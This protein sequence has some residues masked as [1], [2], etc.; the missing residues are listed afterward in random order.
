MDM[1]ESQLN[2][3]WP[4]TVR[5]ATVLRA[6]S[7]ISGSNSSENKAANPNGLADILHSRL[8]Q[9]DTIIDDISRT[10][11]LD[12]QSLQL[13]T[14][15]ASLYVLERV[16][17][18]LVEHEEQHSKDSAVS[19]P[20]GSKDMAQIRTHIS[21]VFN[22]GTELLTSRILPSLPD[23]PMR[24]PAIP[25]GAQIIDLTATHENYTLLFDIATRLLSIIFPEGP[26]G[27]SSTTFVAMTIWSRG[28]TDLLKTCI[29]LAWL[30]S[31][32]RGDVSPVLDVKPYIS[33][34]L[35]ASSPAQSI[36]ALGS[37][38]RK[39]QKPLY[40][41]KICRMLSTEQLLRP[42]GIA[43][44]LSSIFGEDLSS[45][46]APLEKLQSTSN[47]LNT[48]PAHMSP[49]EYYPIIIPRLLQLLS[50]STNKTIPPSHRR[51]ASFALSRMLTT[52]SDA[53][54]A[55][56]ADVRRD[57]VAWCLL[58]SFRPV[59][60]SES[61]NGI[62][63]EVT[64][65]ESTDA[66]PTGGASKARSIAANALV[67]SPSQAIPTLSTILLNTDPSPELIDVLLTPIAARL[68]TLLEH[69]LVSKTADP[70][71][72][73]TVEGL[74][75]I[76]TRT[77]GKKEIVGALWEVVEGRGGEWDVDDTGELRVFE[78]S[79]SLPSLT[80]AQLA[81]LQEGKLDGEGSEE[82]NP[83]NLHP[84]PLYFSRFVKS[85]KR[86][87]VAS[88]LYLRIL[89]AH[90]KLDD[91]DDPLRKLLLLKLSMQISS[92]VGTDAADDSP[93]R[94]P[95]VTRTLM[96]IKVSLDQ[97]D[98]LREFRTK[99]DSQGKLSRE[100]LK[101]V[102]DE[103][104]SDESGGDSDDE[105]LAPGLEGVSKRE[106]LSVTAVNLLLA[107]LQEHPDLSPKTEPLL[108][109]I[110]SQLEPL[111][112]SASDALRPLAREARITLTARLASSSSAARPKESGKKDS[113]ESPQGKY[114]RALKLLQDPL[115]PVR[116]H[117]LLLLRE[118]VAPAKTT[119]VQRRGKDRPD[120][121]SGAT[122][123]IVQGAEVRAP[124]VD[125]ALIPAILSIFMQSIQDEDSYIFLNAV[126]GL[127]AMVDGF[128]RDVLKGLVVEYSKGLEGIGGSAAAMTS[129]EV[130][131]RVRI[132][133][134]LGQVIRRCG[135]VL[136]KYVDIIV[137]SLFAVVRAAH[138]PTT[139]RTSAV[140][141]LATAA[142]TNALALSAYSADLITAMVDLVQVESVR[143]TA[144]LE[145]PE[146][147]RREAAENAHSSDVAEADSDSREMPDGRDE[148]RLSDVEGGIRPQIR[149]EVSPELATVKDRNEFR[150]TAQKRSKSEVGDDAD[151]E[152]GNTMDARPTTANSKFPPLR[153]AALHFL[154]LLLRA[155]ATQVHE[156]DH[157][158]GRGIVVPSGPEMK[159]AET[160]LVY[161]SMTDEDRVVRVMAREAA[162]FL[163]QLRKAL[164]G[165]R[166]EI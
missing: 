148:T 116:A 150:M 87:D 157:A 8:E 164:L 22:W 114:Q 118:L 146:P 27:P 94:R 121:T 21:V 133:E 43:G 28:F 129:R 41:R 12:L 91:N 3:S 101:F 47:V 103:S 63:A 155:H 117:G 18:L 17:S 109:E 68:Y 14:A 93:L 53:D 79:T 139:L 156:G 10:R 81:D 112:N 160:V 100:S 137:P 56:R 111:A 25:P 124:S 85:I 144:P 145:K 48:L 136:G 71:I 166:E 107:L 72:R 26:Q 90:V 44:L 113:E 59:H 11:S 163:Q 40:V 7:V 19:L 67:L 105:D 149:S 88:E 34:L 132:G 126:Q 74:L 58:D 98:V 153:R 32:V 128:G 51:A 142:D 70:M 140:S 64:S 24:V 102:S 55:S 16:H 42:A 158:P 151:A 65:T 20:I 143:A 23:K 138:L 92:Q 104:E 45:T 95:D 37:I 77:T 119:P 36:T 5:L 6:G 75:G 147:E 134:A 73:E 83:L 1:Y 115:L 39:M 96:F 35:N 69:L 162:E 159:R 33:S 57:I 60:R 99:S 127:A 62:I 49:E 9:F 106:H 141:L 76:W 61:N 46:E 30:P 54:G 131:L 120:G 125:A 38:M 89:D 123:S 86:Q 4:D 15:Y 84:H 66:E 52:R 2:R 29:F 130:D 135:E 108:N 31:D 161:V 78:R 152:I 165:L 82:A 122:V 154:S 50:P 80:L 110:Y 97:D 13:D